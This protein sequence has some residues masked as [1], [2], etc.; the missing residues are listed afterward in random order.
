MERGGLNVKFNTISQ[1]HNY[2]FKESVGC[3]LQI[4][5]YPL[6]S[7]EIFSREDDLQKQHLVPSSS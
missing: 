3:S 1:F 2:T 6:K 7:T 4:E 5:T